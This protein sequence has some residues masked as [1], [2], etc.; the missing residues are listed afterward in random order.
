M[1]LG[2]T[3]AFSAAAG[4][5]VCLFAWLQ[6][7]TENARMG[8]SGY[9]RRSHIQA[10]SPEIVESGWKV[11]L[12]PLKPLISCKNVTKRDSVESPGTNMVNPCLRAARESLGVH[13]KGR[14]P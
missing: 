5:I 14:V 3:L 11:H 13:L 10:N 7:L 9:E 6:C 8:R 1:T 2:A 12:A 4:M